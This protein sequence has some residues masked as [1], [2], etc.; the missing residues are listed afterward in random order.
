MD[1]MFSSNKLRDLC[2]DPKKA[3]KKYSNKQA[4]LLHRRLDD[5]RAA[6]VLADF[7][8]L[9]GKCHELRGDR[10]GQLALYLEGGDRPILEPADNPIPR[11]DDGGLDWSQVTMVRILEIGDYHD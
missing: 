9:P 11:K 4:K 7:R 6:S 2:N 5:L 8:N 1:I 10:A 3:Q